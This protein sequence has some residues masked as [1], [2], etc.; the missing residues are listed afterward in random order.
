[1]SPSTSALDP[2]PYSV[3]KKTEVE[4]I[5]KAPTVS[6]KHFA[7]DESKKIYDLGST[8]GTFMWV[9]RETSAEI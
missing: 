9:Q 1:M 6:S 8:K 7:I 2:S 4:H 3:V 5:L